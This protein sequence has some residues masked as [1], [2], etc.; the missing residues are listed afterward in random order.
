MRAKAG[1]FALL[2]ALVLA[3]APLSATDGEAFRGQSLIEALREL[4]AR[5][6][7]LVF[8]S[9][10]VRPEMKVEVEPTA[11]DDREVLEQL[12][13]PHGL[14]TQEGPGETLIIVP[15][16]VAGRVGSGPVVGF[17]RSRADGSGVA[18]ATV[19]VLETGAEVTTAA[20]GSFEV[21]LSPQGLFTL[22]ARRRG[23]VLG[24]VGEVGVG[25]GSIE[26]EIVLDP[27]PVME[28]ELL[29]TP[30]RVSILR[31]EPV[32]QLD[33][34]RDDIHALPHLGGDFFRALSLLPGLA[35]NDVSAQFHVRGGRRDE[36]QILLDGQELYEVYH[37]QD[38]DSALSVIAPTTLENVDLITG[39]FPAEHGDRMS[40][41]L[42]MTT[43]TPT[44]STQGLIGIGLL[45][46]QLGGAGVFGAERQGSWLAQVRRG[47]IDLAN[48]LLGN[49]DPRYWD[50]FGKVDYRLGAR[51][52]LRAN[53]LH[54]DDHLTFQEVVDSE[55][56]R[57]DTN[58]E[59]S[60]LWLTHQSILSSELL[61]ENAASASR[62]DRDRFG[63][64]LEDDVQ[65]V[66]NDLRQLDVLSLRQSWTSQ[67]SR[68]HF[69]KWGFEARKF[70]T[71]YDY[72]GITSFQNPLAV[73][74]ENG[75][76]SA[77]LFT[78]RFVEYHYSAHLADR[79]RL[80]PELTLELGVRYDEHTQTDESL[81]SPR[82]NLAYSPGER[83]VFR[84]A[85][86]RFTQSQR[87]Y[88][89][90]VEDGETSFFPVERSEH[91]VLGYQRLFGEG[92]R[93]VVLRTEVYR[94]T[95]TN[96]RPRYENMYEPIN[97]FPEVEPDRVRIAPDRSIAEGVEL[98][99]KGRVGRSSR[100]WINYTY[101]ST[102]D[103]LN[104]VLVPRRFD[105][106]H[107]LN[108]DF[109]YRPGDKWRFNFAW[110]YHTGWPTTALTLSEGLDEDGEVIFTPVLGPLYGER[111]PDYHR[112]DLRAGR[113]WKTRI[114]LLTFYVDIQNVY[115]RA[116]IGGFDFEIDEEAGTILQ[117][118]EEWAGFLP[119]AGI[120]LEF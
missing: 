16:S 44:G 3:A 71:D 112:L 59:S 103:R 15:R 22:E 25:A 52:S 36:T 17:V 6:L 29:V 89:L 62:I 72:S 55:S 86:G 88:E 10:V 4:N 18:G 30:S 9:S 77:I 45:S 49:E 94:R 105:Q 11:T 13:L 116:N 96:P 8:T 39:G 53:L 106:T 41:V 37:L 118:G 58:Y 35:G 83:S 23:F 101:S 26:V 54:A 27:A 99:L 117:I 32:A 92:S 120:L 98:F 47:S 75:S 74:R 119:S 91:R 21:G 79:M 87:P 43:I 66:I 40:G 95:V 20:D 61:L 102:E 46:A 80:S 70:D 48:Q 113:D 73:I 90:Q 34:S 64:E 24:Q 19:R 33:F 56:K 84:L 31:E 65:F 97:T 63:I 104:G 107:S 68:Q 93:G 114:G 51:N 14:T 42:D 28:E 111:L 38:Y 12:L 2:L 69:V 110:R 7:K 1:S 78:D 100:W 85:W 67:P 109:D 60:Y 115:D 50:A 76:D 57:I 5:G 108:L 82:L 81:V